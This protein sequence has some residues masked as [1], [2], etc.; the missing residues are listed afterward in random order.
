MGRGPKSNCAFTPE[1]R[2]IRTHT[3][4]ASTFLPPGLFASAA[5]RSSGLGLRQAF[6][7]VTQINSDRLM[8]KFCIHFA[9]KDRSIKLA[10]LDHASAC[11]KHVH[12]QDS[13]FFCFLFF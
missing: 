12:F 7:L 3:S 8:H 5:D 6:S 1:R 10:G 13:S 2:T 9:V 11:I 4:P